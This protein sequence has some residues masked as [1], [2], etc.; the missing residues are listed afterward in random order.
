MEL[1]TEH[2]Y[3]AVLTHDPR[4]DGAFFVGV[5]STGIYCRTVCTAKT[6]RRENCVFY[7]SAAAA[8]RAGYRPCLRCRPELAPGRS[9]IDSVSRLAAMAADRIEDGALLEGGVEALATQL[10]VSGRHLRRVVEQEFGVT[11]IE[12]AQTARLLAAKRLLT[13]TDLSVTDV[14]FASG[15][16]SLRRMNALFKERYRMNPTGLRN[17]RTT[18]RASEPIVCEVSYRP[19]LEWGALL[20]FLG[21]RA[22]RGVE[23]IEGDRHPRSEAP[24][25]G[26]AGSAYDVEAI[27]RDRRPPSGRAA[28]SLSSSPSTADEGARYLRTASFGQYRG[29]L[30]VEPIAG[31]DALRVEISLSLA[32]ALRSVVASVKR[33]FDLAAAPVEIAAHLG[34]MAEDRP[35]LRV[36]GAFSGFEL[37]VRAILGQQ[38]SVA[39]ATTLSGR[40]HHAFGEAIETPSPLLT[41]LSP[42]AERIARAEPGELTALGILASR[43]VSIIALARAVTEG[44]ILLQ[45]GVDV[46]RTMAQLKELPGVGEWTAQYIAMRA[47]GWPDAFPHTDLGL[48]KAL[49]ETEP[50]RILERAESWRPWRAYAAMQLWKS[51][52]NRP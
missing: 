27:E 51:L 6:P 16:S 30:G 15:F 39:A 37:A 32:A 35:G 5:S 25:P 7:R 49:G 19:P 12:L 33:L 43:S 38:V 8:E 26:A 22:C 28:L 21:G 29:W 17:G 41:R 36:P 9:R 42:T 48:M 14:A 20:Q 13:D 24:L 4:F 31:K 23:A 3:Q 10:G 45:P 18:R 1:N 52:E 46:P 50:K 34:P 44:R 11:P 2:C 47:L 40:Y